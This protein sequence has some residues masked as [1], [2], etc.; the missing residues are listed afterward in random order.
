M[1]G[2]KS[3]DALGDWSLMNSSSISPQKREDHL[4]LRLFRGHIVSPNDV[5]FLMRYV[6][7]TGD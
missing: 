6:F 4:T 7:R 3:I 1:L 2:F 5:H